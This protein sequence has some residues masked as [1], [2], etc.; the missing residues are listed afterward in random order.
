MAEQVQLTTEL[1]SDLAKA[2]ARN[3]DLEEEA[4]EANRRM[5]NMEDELGSIQEAYRSL[6]NYVY[7]EQHPKPSEL[8]IKEVEL[9]DQLYEVQ[10][11]VREEKVEELKKILQS[12][13]EEIKALQGHAGRLEADLL[14]TSFEYQELIANLKYKHQEELAAARVTPIEVPT[15][16]TETSYLD[17]GVFNQLNLYN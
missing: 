10:N 5:K 13:N 11:R 4:R 3:K 6:Y 15:P 7:T 12:R 14:K 1:H 2:E 9:N 16:P 17:R 8:V